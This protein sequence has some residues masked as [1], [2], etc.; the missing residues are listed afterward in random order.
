MQPTALKPE[1]I[2][3]LSRY[4][5]LRPLAQGLVAESLITGRQ[6]S[7][8]NTSAVRVILSLVH[9]VK[10]EHLLAGVEPR[11]AAALQRF[12][13]SCL[14]DGLITEID[15]GGAAAEDRQLSLAAWEPHDLAFHLR[16]R[17]GRT[18]LPVGATWH[19]SQVVPPEPALAP[20]H[21]GTLG[22]ICLDKPDLDRL[23]ETDWT[24]TRALEARR[25]R[26]SA[27]PVTL[28]ALAELLFRA[29][30]ITSQFSVNGEPLHRHV[31][32]SGGARHSLGVYILAH[33][34]VGLSRGAYRYDGLQH[35]LEWLREQ[36]EDQR[37]L[38][39]EAQIGTGILQELPSVLLI[40]SSRIA[41]VTRKYQSN[42]YRVVV[43]EVGGLYQT[44]YLIAE[45]LGLAASAIGAG[46]AERFSRALRLDF[47]AEPSVGEMILGG[48]PSGAPP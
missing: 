44:L 10:L 48:A 5:Q 46:D 1:G 23:R 2:Y 37:A 13:Q 22:V 27:A 39:R 47:F 19:L 32:P 40:L 4:C 29:C 43:K 41:R 8:P 36:D 14:G 18:P 7:L 11:L 38:L 30:R 9:P 25:T 6:R 15:P 26:Y 28:C 35:R 21:G 17:R 20:P 3:R 45:T 34:C 31:Y 24:L 33:R 42:A 12:L 16:S